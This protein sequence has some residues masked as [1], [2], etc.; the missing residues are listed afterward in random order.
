MF[1]RKE[2]DRWFRIQ[3]LEGDRYSELAL[4]YFRTKE[5]EEARG[6]IYLKDVTEIYDH[7]DRG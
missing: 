2:D 5:E 6:W 1:Q 3:E 7:S 4:L